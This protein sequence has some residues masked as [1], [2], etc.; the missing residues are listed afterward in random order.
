MFRVVVIALA[1]K[2]NENYF[3]RRPSR[4]KEAIVVKSEAEP[5]SR[6]DDWPSIIKGQI[7]SDS[8]HSEQRNK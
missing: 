2:A 1:K 7:Q 6:C 5:D 4:D 3:S 8:I